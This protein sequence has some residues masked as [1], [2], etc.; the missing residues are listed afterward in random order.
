[1]GEGTVVMVNN[2]TG[3]FTPAFRDH[4]SAEYPESKVFDDVN[5]LLALTKAFHDTKTDHGRKVTELRT[6]NDNL[7][8]ANTKMET[9]VFPLA[10]DAGDEAKADYGKRLAALNGFDGKA[11]SYKLPRIDG[12]EYGDTEIATEKA[13][14]DM[15]IEKGIPPAVVNEFTDFHNAVQKQLI[16][17]E[18]TEFKADCEKFDADHPGDKKQVAL[19]CV[20]QALEHFADDATK[21]QIKDARLFDSTDLAAW[22][23]VIPIAT[24]RV[25][26]Q[27]H[28]KTMVGGELLGSGATV[29]LGD[30]HADSPYAKAFKAYPDQ[31][32]MWEGLSKDA[33][34]G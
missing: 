31:P 8:T 4:V 19:R 34:A 12:I 16:A 3:D 29:T 30:A 7:T 23:K 32:E 26:E 1:M 28:A 13:V 9:G 20:C 22:S 11:E 6:A 15:C 14:V 5:G 17:D 33:P 25:F 27:V 10:K 2:E 18:Q 21:K 24:I